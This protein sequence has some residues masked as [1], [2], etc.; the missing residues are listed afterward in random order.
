MIKTSN[1]FLISEFLINKVL[2]TVKLFYE[3]RI[4]VN[5]QEIPF[6]QLNSIDCAGI[7][8]PNIYDS[9]TDADLIILVTA[10]FTPDAGF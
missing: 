9:S 4:Y 10:E 8:F 3:S 7:A 1:Y 6:E 2:P 5:K